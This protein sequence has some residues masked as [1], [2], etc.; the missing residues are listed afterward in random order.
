MCGISI[1]GDKTVLLKDGCER[2]H[3]Q[4]DP[5]ITVTQVGICLK[6]VDCTSVK[7]KLRR[8]GLKLGSVS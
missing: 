4:V 5:V 2:Q 7:C 3:V 6:H 8:D 1:L